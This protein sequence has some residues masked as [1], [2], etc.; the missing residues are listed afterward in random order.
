MFWG[1]RDGSEVKSACCSFE[2]WILAPR[3]LLGDSRTPVT[4]APRGPLPLASVGDSALMYM[5]P[6]SWLLFLTWHKTELSGKWNVPSVEKMTSSVWTHC[7]D[8]CGEAQP[9]VGGAS[10]GQGVLGGIR[11]QTEQAKGNKPVSNS[12]LR[13]HLQFLSPGS[14]PLWIFILIS[15][16]IHCDLDM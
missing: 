13:S 4:L 10:L 8:W 14:Y 6:L 1:Q 3:T 7:N 5:Q 16:V 9:T 11:T 2:D 15:S 12:S